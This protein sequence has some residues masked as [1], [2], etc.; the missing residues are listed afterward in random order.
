M[1]QRVHYLSVHFQLH[2]I[3]I[4]EILFKPIGL[5]DTIN[6][7]YLTLCGQEVVGRAGESN[8]GKWGQLQLNNTKIKKINN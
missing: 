3:K 8:G 5:H 1:P 7:E 4:Q 2:N 6:Q